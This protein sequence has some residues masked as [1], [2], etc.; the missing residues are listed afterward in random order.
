MNWLKFVVIL[1]VSLPHFAFSSIQADLS[2]RHILANQADSIVCTFRLPSK[3]N[4]SIKFVN[5]Y[6]GEEIIIEEN[7]PRSPGSQKIVLSSHLM[8][9]QRFSSGVYYLQIQ[10]ENEKN[11]TFNF[12]SFQEPWGEMVT[13][14]DVKLD[15]APGRLATS[16]LKSH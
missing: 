8:N 2:K 15:R 1:C 11:Q 12:D 7:K 5:V 10:G 9:L 14:T 13:A 3:M 16:C 6:G 4:T